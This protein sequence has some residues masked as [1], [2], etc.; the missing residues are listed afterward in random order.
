MKYYAN[1]FPDFL[2]TATDDSVIN[3]KSGVEIYVYQLEYSFSVC[4]L[5]CT[6]IIQVKIIAMIPA[7]C[8]IPVNFS[9]VNFLSDSRVACDSLE[10]RGV[11]K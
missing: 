5:D 3:K 8:K 1:T 9:K 6:P 7:L 10:K 2:I 11:S 4:V